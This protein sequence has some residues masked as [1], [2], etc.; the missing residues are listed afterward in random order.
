MGDVILGAV[1]AIF[2][3]IQN[4]QQCWLL[5]LWLLCL[6]FFCRLRLC[7]MYLP[8]LWFLGLCFFLN[9]C[10]LSLG[11]LRLCFLI[12][13]FLSWCLVCL[14]R[15]CFLFEPWLGG[16]LVIVELVR[17]DRPNMPGCFIVCHRFGMT[18]V[19]RLTSRFS[20][21]LLALPFIG[22]VPPL[23]VATWVC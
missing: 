9:L 10:F 23:H 15:L 8:F 18:G 16:D 12:L 19:V 13:S 6:L 11:F 14:L 2:F 17:T 22:V 5:S 20:F 7:L 21:L 3:I 4:V 1:Y